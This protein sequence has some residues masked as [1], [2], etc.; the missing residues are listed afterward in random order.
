MK[1]FVWLVCCVV[2]WQAT[3]MTSLTLKAMQERNLCL[4]GTLLA[5]LCSTSWAMKT[6]TLWTGQFVEFILTHRRNE[7]WNERWSVFW[8]NLWWLDCMTAV[9]IIFHSKICQVLRFLN[10]IEVLTMARVALW[11]SKVITCPVAINTAVTMLAACALNPPMAPAMAEPTKFLLTL[12]SVSAGTVVFKTW[13]KENNKSENCNTQVYK[14][15]CL[16]LLVY[17]CTSQDK[18]T[19]W[20][21]PHQYFYNTWN[22]SSD[23]LSYM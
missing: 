19:Y 6:Y 2:G 17:I 13:C 8:V 16:L 20:T 18:C 4:Q 15:L 9:H 22:L 3:G 12:S 1:L 10:N 23:L 11:G 7:I 14:L 21:C 5:L